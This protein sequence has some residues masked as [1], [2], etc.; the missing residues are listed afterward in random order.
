ML[1]QTV[2][3][4]RRGEKVFF[5][6]VGSESPGLIPADASTWFRIGDNEPFL[7][8]GPNAGTRSKD[9]ERIVRSVRFLS[10][11]SPHQFGSF[12]VSLEL[13]Y[14][15]FQQ[16]FSGRSYE[17]AVALAYLRVFGLL[18]G[19][20]GVSIVATGKLDS[21][22]K[23][24]PVERLLEKFDA[25]SV[26]LALPPEDFEPPVTLLMPSRDIGSAQE[27]LAE[28]IQKLESQG[29]TVLGVDSLSQLVA[30]HGVKI[31][32]AL[33][34]SESGPGAQEFGLS[35]RDPAE[36]Q[37]KGAQGGESGDLVP[38][39]DKAPIS[40][41]EPE[42]LISKP[43]WG[44]FKAAGA[45]SV[46]FPMVAVLAW[47]WAVA[48]TVPVG[49][50]A[51]PQ[52]SQA[53]AKCFEPQPLSVRAQCKFPEGNGSG[54]WTDC[55]SPGT[56][57]G[58]DKVR[59]TMQ[60][61]VDGYLYVWNIDDE[62]GLMQDIIEDSAKRVYFQGS[63]VTLPRQGRSFEIRRGSDDVTFV[64]VLSDRPVP[65]FDNAQDAE[66]FASPA[67]DLLLEQGAVVSFQRGSRIDV[68]E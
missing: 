10:E 21:K 7:W 32:E 18:P 38:L 3:R 46:F 50:A 8:L 61:T 66:L 35:A 48:T 52:T 41:S 20:D 62:Q 60:S 16:E 5:P 59:L 33:P 36:P 42:S 25:I 56:L 15:A 13:E 57:H 12:E 30:T 9:I 31:A 27:N 23:I 2:K 45:I 6:I 34:S 55:P 37:G 19:L 63:R 67:K 47:W 65:A 40:A 29:V 4:D 28:G 54:L 49:C 43:R 53:L 1:K 17:L 58:G 64:A 51:L 44:F 11:V 14:E 24:H 39:S 22:G 26:A 68:V